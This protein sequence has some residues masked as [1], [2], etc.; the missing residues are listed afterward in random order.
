MS[1]QIFDSSN[2][3]IGSAHFRRE[4]GQSLDTDGNVVT[5]IAHVSENA[6]I[7]TWLHK[8]VSVT[9]AMATPDTIWS[10][11]MAFVGED[12]HPQAAT[13]TLGETGGLANYYLAHT[14]P[15]ITGVPA[16]RGIK[17]V[18]VYPRVDLQHHF[19]S[20][21][22]TMTFIFRPGAQP[23]A[24]QLFF[25]GQDSLG[26][27]L[28]GMLRVYVGQRF[29]RLHEAY[30]YQLG[31]GNDHIPVLW[32]PSYETGNGGGLVSF[33]FGAYD[34]SKPLLFEIGPPPLAGGGG[35]GPDNLEWSTMVGTDLPST[36]DDES[37]AFVEP[38]A[39]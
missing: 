30:A 24:V 13:V 37:G 4:Q 8:D 2:D 12:F 22:H 34:S 7:K 17:R 16:F 23:S 33:A 1:A 27:D 31:P 25:T 3:T 28:Q 19:G 20:T 38:L 36:V 6:P 18:D 15:G 11:N 39:V 26:V 5:T 9:W 10:V 32:S 35:G 21:G 14:A 29:L